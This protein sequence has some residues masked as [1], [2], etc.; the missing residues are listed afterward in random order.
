VQ[1][2]KT[3]APPLLPTSSWRYDFRHGS[4][5]DGQH[6]AFLTDRIGEWQIWVMAADGGRP[7]PLFDAALD[8][9]SLE[10]GSLGERALSWTQ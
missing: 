9:L 3:P 5:A 4:G 10:Y 6:L 1:G 8:G 2:G 7:R